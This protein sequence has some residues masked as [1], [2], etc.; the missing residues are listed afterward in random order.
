MKKILISLDNTFYDFQ[1]KIVP[2][3]K[4]NYIDCEHYYYIVYRRMK[5]SDL[6]IIKRSYNNQRRILLKR[7]SFVSNRLRHLFRIAEKFV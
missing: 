2:V 5:K 3:A 6:E 7:N 4:N 1:Y